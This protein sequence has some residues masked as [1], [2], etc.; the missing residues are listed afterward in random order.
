MSWLDEDAEET[1]EHI[2]DLQ[3]EIIKVNK[4]RIAKVEEQIE[5]CAKQMRVCN[6]KINRLKEKIED[7]ETA[8]ADLVKDLKLVS[9]GSIPM[10]NFKCELVN[11]KRE[12]QT[13][14]GKNWDLV[15]K[16]TMEKRAAD[17][18]KASLEMKL[19]TE[20][21]EL[22]EVESVSIC[23]GGEGGEQPAA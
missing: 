22:K 6:G 19:K 1:R 21:E 17:L 7:D 18:Q 3:E 5:S 8:H 20:Q 16:F 2:Q 11:R 4:A 13:R 15:A 23:G 12:V 14:I 9:S 10:A